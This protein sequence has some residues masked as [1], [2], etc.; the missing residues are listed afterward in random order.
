[1]TREPGREFYERE[2]WSGCAGSGWE[3]MTQAEKDVCA[4]AERLL[5]ADRA[6]WTRQAIVDLCERYPGVRTALVNACIDDY[7]AAKAQGR[8]DG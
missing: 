8:P 3:R 5:S 4:T 2:C 6:E 1:M 7:A